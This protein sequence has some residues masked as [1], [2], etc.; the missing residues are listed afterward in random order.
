MD[1]TQLDTCV[2]QICECGCTYV[3]EVIAILQA[4]GAS[5]ETQDATPVQ[6]AHILQQLQDI[7]AVYDAQH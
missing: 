5:L 3:R 7:M 4:H 6:R 2:T 1:E